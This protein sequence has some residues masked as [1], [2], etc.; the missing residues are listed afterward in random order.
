MGIRINNIE[1]FIEEEVDTKS[2]FEELLEEEDEY[3][4]EYHN[5]RK[6]K[7]KSEKDLAHELEGI[8][9][10]KKSN[11]KTARI[12]DLSDSIFEVNRYDRRLIF[13]SETV[14]SSRNKR[15]RRYHDE[16]DD[17]EERVSR[18]EEKESIRDNDFTINDLDFEV[19]SLIDKATKHVPRYE[20]KLEKK[21]KYIEERRNNPNKR[22][23]KEN[24]RLKS[25][26]D[27]LDNDG[28]ESSS[29]NRAY[30][31]L[32]PK[33]DLSFLRF[34]NLTDIETDAVESM[35]K[36]IVDSVSDESVPN[37]IRN[38]IFKTISNL[39][40]SASKNNFL[41]WM[42]VV[43]S[44]AATLTKSMKGM[45]LLMMV[46]SKISEYSSKYIFTTRPGVVCRNSQTEEEVKY[47]YFDEE[48]FNDLANDIYEILY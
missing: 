1:E 23:D 6:V 2:I 17:I 3:E 21:K 25:I 14:V 13:G 28:I 37:S 19:V 16:D 12:M 40:K 5:R 7:Y 38:G 26:F 11:R 31:S 22:M 34:D 48:S 39:T 9:V 44:I 33:L 46:C 10:E 15:N 4:D 20:R 41:S 30:Q 47:S 18:V 8:P 29:L 36:W 42:Q 43:H 45:K 27:K 32:S 35:F 24:V